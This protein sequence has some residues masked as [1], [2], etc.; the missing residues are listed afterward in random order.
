MKISFSFLFLVCVTVVSAQLTNPQHKVFLA[1]GDVKIGER[2]TYETAPTG[3]Q[4]FVLD[5]DRYDSEDVHFFQN[6]HGYFA[7]LN[8]VLGNNKE[9]YALRIRKGNLSLYEEIEMEVYGGE[10][11]KTEGEPGTDIQDPMLASGKMFE[12]YQMAGNDYVRKA[13]YANLNVDLAGNTESLK[14]LGSFKK[15]RILQWALLGIG[16]GIIAMDVLRQSGGGVQFNPV[17]AFGFVVG[18]GSYLLETPKRDALW[19]AADAYNQEE[20]MVEK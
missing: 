10:E 20:P 8:R 9:R 7:N 4:E 13:T 18:G 12:Y 11:L 6:N 1:S 17:M 3:R 2:L 14:H 16:S 19:L 5:N 15:F